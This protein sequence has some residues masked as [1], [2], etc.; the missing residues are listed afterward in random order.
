MSYLQGLGGISKNWVEEWK[1]PFS[2]GHSADRMMPFL[3]PLNT[4]VFLQLFMNPS[5]EE[6]VPLEL[7]STLLSSWIQIRCWYWSKFALCEW[8][9]GGSFRGDA[10]VAM[11]VRRRRRRMGLGIGWWGVGCRDEGRGF[12]VEGGGV[13]RW[14][15][16]VIKVCIICRKFYRI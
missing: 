16:Y 3:L 1:S 14:G 13:W 15:E 9:V 11:M 7:V 12:R 8:W 5:P 2:S 6:S 10:R 4:C